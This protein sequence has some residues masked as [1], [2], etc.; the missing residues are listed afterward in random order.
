MCKIYC[1]K[2]REEDKAREREK[3]T[4]EN[5]ERKRRV[6]LYLSRLLVSVFV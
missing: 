2:L 1:G 6:Q 4:W 3:Q 5:G